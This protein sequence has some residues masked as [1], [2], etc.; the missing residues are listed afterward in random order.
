M[1]PSKTAE[2]AA[3][4]LR[5]RLL[6]VSAGLGQ[7]V[8]WVRR[9]R[10]PGLPSDVDEGLPALSLPTAS[11]PDVS[12]V[13]PAYGKCA[14]TWACLQSLAQAKTD[15]PFEVIVVD[16]ASPDRTARVLSSV[17]GL[18]LHE[19]PKN[20][21]FIGSCN[22]GADLA[23]AKWLCLLN[24]DTRVTDNWLDE[25][26]A[27]FEQ[28]P[29]AGMVG[30]RL[31]FPDGRLQEAGGTVFRDGSTS[32]FGRNRD[33][34]RPEFGFVREVDFCSGACL[35]LP[36]SLYR[37]LGG[38]DAHYAPAYC[39]D[40]DLA[41]RVRARGLSVLYQPL[42]RVVH[43]EGVTHGRDLDRGVKRYQR[44]NRDKLR[45]RFQETL[46]ASHPAPGRRTA[47]AADR[48]LG[49]GLLVLSPDAA[50]ATELSA[51]PTRFASLP[52]LRA[53]R[54]LGW[55]VAVFARNGLPLDY[56]R[57]GIETLGPPYVSSKLSPIVGSRAAT[58]DVCWCDDGP[59]VAILHEVIRVTA[60]HLKSVVSVGAVGEL[61]EQG[62]ARVASADLIVAPDADN[63]AALQARAPALNVISATVSDEDLACALRALTER[64]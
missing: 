26:V 7:A 35:L 46:R 58:L 54:K 60:G 25:L 53:L 61:G 55:K 8:R 56:A 28:H 14:T 13:I 34:A 51:A 44:I 24:N 18:K 30:A 37:E 59:F 11:D 4:V 9:E 62:L 49:P 19:N 12:I 48:R 36:R 31:L 57:G 23:K 45:A 43:Y 1:A 32:H 33:P 63:A 64:R 16:D 22:V 2:T 10:F 39:E 3:V 6:S 42:C 21:G 5:E 27:T 20:L 17:G 47:V 38:F 41:F 50:S 15:V 29:E 52:R 40:V